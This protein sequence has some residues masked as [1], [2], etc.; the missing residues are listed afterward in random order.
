MMRRSRM[1]CCRCAQAEAVGGWRRGVRRSPRMVSASVLVLPDRGLYAAADLC[2]PPL[3][4]SRC[5]PTSASPLSRIQLLELELPKMIQNTP[6]LSG[7]AL[8]AG[9]GVSLA[10]AQPRAAP[11]GGS[12]AARGTWRTQPPPWSARGATARRAG[13]DTPSCRASSRGLQDWLEAI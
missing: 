11:A 9:V 3:P 7:A 12:P 6:R 8:S 5:S 1:R 4:C 2:A 10:K 13:T